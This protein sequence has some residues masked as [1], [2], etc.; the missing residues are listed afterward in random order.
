MAKKQYQNSNKNINVGLISLGCPKNTV[1]S[2]AI[3]GKIAHRGYTIVGDINLADVMIVNTCGF[4]EPAKQE[5]IA[6]LKD[7]AQYKQNGRLRLLIAA[8]CLA[9]RMGEKL[10]EQVPEIDIIAALDSRDN[11]DAIIEQN[12][13]Q[14]NRCLYAG[15][16]SDFISD[17]RGRLLTNPGHYAYLRISE[18]CNW[19]CAFCTIPSIRGSFRSKPLKNIAR[20]AEELAKSGVKELI[21]IAQ[22][23]NNYGKDLGMDNGLAELLGVLENFGFK[24]LRVMYMY[25]AAVT[26]A[27]IE[28]MASSKIILPYVDMP[29]QH[30][31][32]T[33]LKSMKRADTKEKT[34]RLIEKL[35]L[36]MPNVVLRTT[37]ITG[38]PG[39]TESCHNELVEFVKWAKFDALGCFTYF[40]EEGTAAAAL[41]G[42]LPQDVKEKRMDEIMTAQQEIVFAKN[43]AMIGKELDVIVDAVYKDNTAQG[44]YY[45]QAPDID[46]VCII[47]KSARKPIRTGSIIPVKIKDYDDYDLIA[48][49]LK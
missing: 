31:N 18:G 28:K 35:R 16:D 45:G 17:D 38:Y 41:D 15:Q 30:I 7:V 34:T 8:G 26:D 25:P 23:T 43:Q 4:I 24:W 33:I 11:I 39:E 48:Y 36:A 46:S 47:E 19:R 1:D 32:D 3:L 9:Q 10:K 6:Q 27:L 37:V 21:I 14:I 5:A 49:P 2:E 44:R 12:L 20:E 29:I 42:Q 13:A 22:D 40:A